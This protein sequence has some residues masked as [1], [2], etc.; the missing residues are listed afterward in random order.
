[1]NVHNVSEVRQIEVQRAEPLVTGPSR[2]RVEI[3]TA[4]LKKYISPDSDEIPAEQIQA[5]GETLLKTINSLILFRIMKNF[6]NNGK[7][8]PIYKKKDK[9]DC[10]N[11]RGISLLSNSYEMLSDILLSRLSP[12]MD[13]IIGGS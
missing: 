4:K 8:V 12:H 3:P 13:E 9:T 2:L 1:L 7:I 11:Y 5:E 10:I 6:L